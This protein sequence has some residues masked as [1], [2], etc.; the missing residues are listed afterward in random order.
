MRLGGVEAGGT[1]F[2][3][4]VGEG[5][6]ITE[7]VSFP[8]TQP[9][10]TIARAI[11]FFRDHEVAA[12]GIASF[13]P[14]DLDRTS[15]TYGYI[16]ATPKEGWRNIDIAGP[17]VK[18][19]GL[20]I[21][22]DTDVNGAALGE[23]VWGAGQG[24]GDV[25]YLTVGTGIGGGALSGGKPVHGM[26]HPE[27]GHVRVPRDSADPFS[28]CC[29]FHGDCLEGLASGTAMFQRWG[30]RAQ[31]LGDD[32]PAWRMEA[33]YLALGI[34]NFVMTL[35]PQRVI[36]GGGVMH[37]TLLYDLVR[38]EFHRLVNG[39]LQSPLLAN[40]DSYIVAPGL[41]DDAGVLGAIALARHALALQ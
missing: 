10:E 3:C 31:D 29:P 19:F 35:S 41:G 34:L 12:I 30:A 6:G 36:A 2:V 18:A 21:G 17:F 9:G 16:T 27:M 39:Y 4:A 22:F 7:R 26:I 13:G 5:P 37:R 1:K 14:V 38:E 11:E 8:T 23:S 24:L 28:G 32:H 40:L 20:P 25:L 33:R 15:P